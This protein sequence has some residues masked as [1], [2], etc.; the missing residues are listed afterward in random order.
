MG[1]FVAEWCGMNTGSLFTLTMVFTGAAMAQNLPPQVQ[2]ELLN[3]DVRLIVPIS[4]QE[5]HFDREG[6]LVGEARKGSEMFNSSIFLDRAE[7]KGDKLVLH[8]YRDQV[9]YKSESLCEKPELQRTSR[10]MKITIERDPND[11]S[12]E[13]LSRA[14]P[15]IFQR[16]SPPTTTSSAQDECRVF[17]VADG[18]SPP[19]II[20]NVDPEYP[21]EVRLD[22]RLHVTTVCISGILTTDGK[23]KHIRLKQPT[24][25]DFA[26]EAVSAV[27]QWSFVPAQEDGKPVPIFMS[28]E[29]KFEN[30]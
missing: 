18:I 12:G 25:L 13:V 7:S 27:E 1:L 11:A 5:I 19:H 14:L 22:K 2:S 29:V 10:A 24:R 20:R 26:E 15:R 8:G 21:D 28:I 9:I 4:G 23:I 30:R 3:K 17:H 16:S 6:L